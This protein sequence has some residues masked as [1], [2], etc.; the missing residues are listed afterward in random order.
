MKRFAV[1]FA[2]VAAAAF[3]LPAHAAEPAKGAGTPEESIRS[4][5]RWYVTALVANRDPMKQRTEMKRFATDRLLKE[6]EKMKKGPDGLNGDYF[7]DAQDFDEQWAK[8]ISI[9]N[10]KIEGAKA[11]C[12]VL[13][14]GPEGMRK[15]LVVQ[16]VNEAGAWKIDKVQGR[17][18]GD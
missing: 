9:S 15:K 14:D 5:Y 12:H 4:F 17:D 16:L 2:L 10:V 7:L 3:S 6:I 8:K 1:L 11:S 13:L 18:G